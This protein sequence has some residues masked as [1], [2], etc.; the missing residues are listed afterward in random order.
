[1]KLKYYIKL[2]SFGK[3]IPG[4]L[5][6][7]YKKPKI[8]Y[9]KELEY[10]YT[11]KPNRLK[12]FVN[13]Y[14]QKPVLGS[15]VKSYK[16]PYNTFK[17][18][19]ETVDCNT[20]TTTTTSPYSIGQ[21]YG[22]GIIVYIDGTGQH[23]MIINPNLYGPLH[24]SIT[25]INCGTSQALNEGLNNSN[26]IAAV[27]LNPADAA[28]SFCR[29]LTDEGYNDWFL[30]SLTEWNTAAATDSIWGPNVPGYN[31]NMFYWTSS[32]DIPGDYTAI[33]CK[34]MQANYVNLKSSMLN[35]YAFRYF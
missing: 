25:N 2:N 19:C 29:S 13:T 20:T 1:M 16:K 12:P 6:R 23:G 10:T 5:V 17:E 33:N 21:S 3:V 11:N 32:E 15:L 9:W 30:P 8:G 7:C 26:L 18:V 34:P 35:I 22:G 27:Y 24:W 31:H 14:K 28:G 4:T